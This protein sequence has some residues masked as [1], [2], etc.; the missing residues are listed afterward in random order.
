MSVACWVVVY[1]P[2]I[3]EN[4]TLKSGEGL[5]VSFIVL[6]L[7]GDITNLFGGVLA[8]LLPTMI[9]LAAY[10]SWRRLKLEQQA[11]A[12]ISIPY[13]TSSYYSKYTIIDEIDSHLHPNQA[14]LHL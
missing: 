14:K 12:D 7:L 8:K 9:I 13:A 10:V 4:Y 6:W 5:S 2:Q 3:W 1:T 11:H